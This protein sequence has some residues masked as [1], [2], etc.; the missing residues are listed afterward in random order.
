MVPSQTEI[1]GYLSLIVQRLVSNCNLS[2]ENAKYW[3]N[4][5][6]NMFNDRP[7]IDYTYLGTGQMVLNYVDD[8]AERFK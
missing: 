2:G 5:P 1:D 3:L 6:H 4:N 7:P 8:W